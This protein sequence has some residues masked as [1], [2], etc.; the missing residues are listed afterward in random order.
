MRWLSPTRSSNCLARFLSGRPPREPHRQQ[1]VLQGREAGQQ[2][3][4]LEHVADPLGAEAVALGLGHQRDVPVVDPH[5]A[6]VGPADAGDDVQQRGLAAAAAAD[7]HHLL[8]GRHAELGNIQ[9]RQRRAV[10]LPERFLDVFQ[11]QH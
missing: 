1:H 7:H 3:E 10:R 9:H 8:A 2:I 4:R 11:V 5:L 6:R